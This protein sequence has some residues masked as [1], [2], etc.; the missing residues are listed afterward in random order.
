MV[1]VMQEHHISEMI[2]I[3]MAGLPADRVLAYT[4]NIVIF[5]PTFAEHISGLESVFQ[6]LRS[7]GVTLQ[8]SKGIFGSEKVDF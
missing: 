4:D 7:A 8:Y 3:C 1:S 6:R 2:D 5:S